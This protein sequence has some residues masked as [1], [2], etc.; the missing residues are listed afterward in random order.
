MNNSAVVRVALCDIGMAGS[1]VRCEETETGV[2][3]VESDPDC[4]L[5][6]RHATQPSLYGAINTR[7]S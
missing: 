5:V 7:V 1:K 2:V 3:V 6:S 4:A